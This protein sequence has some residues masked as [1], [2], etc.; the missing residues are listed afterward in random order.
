MNYKEAFKNEDLFDKEM[1]RFLSLDNNDKFEDLFKSFRELMKNRFRSNNADSPVIDYVL[2][3]QISLKIKMLDERSAM[4]YLDFVSDKID[5]VS[6][7]QLGTEKVSNFMLFSEI[8]RNL[9]NVES[10]EYMQKLQEIKGKVDLLRN[11]IVKE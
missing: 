4:S 5:N 8:L 3:K 6:Y 1:S 2:F 11:E 7:N 9:P 10:D